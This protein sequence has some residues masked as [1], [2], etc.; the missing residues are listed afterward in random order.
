MAV[1]NEVLK[2]GW[3]V[4]AAIQ[5]PATAPRDDVNDDAAFDDDID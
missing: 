4:V 1:V 5:A 2:Q 3:A